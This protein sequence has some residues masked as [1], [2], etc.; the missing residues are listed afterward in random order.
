MIFDQFLALV[1]QMVTSGFDFVGGMVTLLFDPIA[2]L[3]SGLF[4]AA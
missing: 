2:A 1:L 4:P 3:I